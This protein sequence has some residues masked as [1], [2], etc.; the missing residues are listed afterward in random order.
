MS[1]IYFIIRILFVRLKSII[2]KSY[3]RILGL[4]IDRKTVIWSKPTISGYLKNI[5]IGYGCCI[6]ERVRIIVNKEESLKIGDNT[7]ISSNVNINSGGGNIE[8]GSNIMIAANTYIIIVI[9]MYLIL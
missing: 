2:L 8:I 9:M 6:D 7:L 4:K 1:K 5:R 3:F